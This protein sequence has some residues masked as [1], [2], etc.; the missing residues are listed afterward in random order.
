M[1][2]ELVN[3]FTH[4]EYFRTDGAS[5]ARIDLIQGR[6]KSLD[7]AS[8]GYRFASDDTL[9][10]PGYIVAVVAPRR[11]EPKLEKLLAGQ[12]GEEVDLPADM[13]AAMCRR[14]RLVE[15]ELGPGHTYY[16]GRRMYY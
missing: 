12:R 9:G 10:R 11:D 6:Q 5:K 7:V 13:W 3:R 4:A 2:L 15:E 1:T 14:A 16:S 8:A